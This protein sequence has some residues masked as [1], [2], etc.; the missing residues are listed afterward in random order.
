[1][2]STSLLNNTFF[3][4]GFTPQTNNDI[5]PTPGRTLA[6]AFKD[7]TGL[8]IGCYTVL[9]Y[10]RKKTGTTSREGLLAYP[11]RPLRIVQFPHKKRG[12][13]PHQ[14]KV[15]LRFVRGAFLVCG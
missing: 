5:A 8:K 12:Q 2:D 3:T 15:R 6:E 4:A 10:S 7:L 14:E 13:A 9:S 1:M 11:V